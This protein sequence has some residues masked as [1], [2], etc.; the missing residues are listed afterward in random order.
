[1]STFK[2]CVRIRP[3]LEE[4]HLKGERITRLKPNVQ[5]K[6]IKISSEKDLVSRS[7][8]FDRVFDVT[9]SQASV[10][11]E[12]RINYLIQKVL[13][14]FSSFPCEYH[15]LSCLYSCWNSLYSWIE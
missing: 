5:Q 3:M 4:E 10:Y 7:F 12:L 2:V 13:E 11:E 8:N 14:V 9:K 15:L 6:E 1:M